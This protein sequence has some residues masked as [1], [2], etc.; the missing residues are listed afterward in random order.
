M[1]Y[2]TLLIEESK[3]SSINTL[4]NN[5]S[6]YIKEKPDPVYLSPLSTPR[7]PPTTTKLINT[8]TTT[9]NT[10]TTLIVIDHLLTMT[11]NTKHRISLIASLI[12]V[13][14]DIKV[15][16]INKGMRI[17]KIGVIEMN[18]VKTSQYVYHTM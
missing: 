4:N 15:K 18:R 5:N 3:R 8:N 11:L 14:K 2:V 10:I 1:E 12:I 17:S 9:Q 6:N 13:N 16:R 7:K